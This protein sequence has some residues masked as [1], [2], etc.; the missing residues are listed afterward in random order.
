MALAQRKALRRL[1]E[2]ASAVRKLFKIHWSLLGA[3]IRP[4]G[5]ARHLLRQDYGG[6]RRPRR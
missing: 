6:F 4:N 5:T 3:P 2:T 1:H